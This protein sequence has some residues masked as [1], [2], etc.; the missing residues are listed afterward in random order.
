MLKISLCLYLFCT[1]TCMQCKCNMSNAIACLQLH[2]VYLYYTSTYCSLR[3]Q[4]WMRHH[5][6]LYCWTCSCLKVETVTNITNTNSRFKVFL[7]LFSIFF[8][9]FF[10]CFLGLAV[11][12]LSAQALTAL[13][14]YR[15]IKQRLFL[16]VK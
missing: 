4:Y 10:G 13:V 9:V 12:I 8:E 3:I 6:G 16:R 15:N 5:P 14:M 11:S 2:K 1:W 7:S